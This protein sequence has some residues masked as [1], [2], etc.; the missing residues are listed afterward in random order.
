M[1]KRANIRK[2]MIIKCTMLN[3]HLSIPIKF[4]IQF[5]LNVF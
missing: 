4:E 1:D 2:Y 5:D 3:I